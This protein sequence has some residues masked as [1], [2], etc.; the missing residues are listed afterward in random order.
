VIIL[1]AC[2]VLLLAVAGIHYERLESSELDRQKLVDLEQIKQQL[3][4]MREQNEAMQKE[5]DS[6]IATAQQEQQ[7]REQEV[8]A[9]VESA[10]REVEA[11][12]TVAE[13][14]E[15]AVKAAQQAED[16]VNKQRVE[17]E[18][19]RAERKRLE[20][21]LKQAELEKQ[22]L[23]KEQQQAELQKKRLEIEVAHQQ[24]LLKQG[25][26]AR[27]PDELFKS[28][29]PNATNKEETDA[30]QHKT[31]KKDTSFDT[32]P[33]SSPSARFLSTCN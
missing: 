2:T 28:L 32:D 19:L 9:A 27:E 6:A 17:E 18:R 21:E 30:T 20:Q 24:K 5:R 11:M 15:K 31:V 8:Q 29:E 3:V 25:K 26:V 7:R 22:R 14:A 23:R 4:R 1:L 12:A 13:T 33:C 10:R 16:L